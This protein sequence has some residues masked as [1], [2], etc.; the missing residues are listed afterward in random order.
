TQDS[1]AT[2]F[3]VQDYQSFSIEALDNTAQFDQATTHQRYF[4][5]TG[6]F[7]F[8]LASF[9]FHFRFCFRSTAT[10]ASCRSFFFYCCTTTA[11]SFRRY[12][13]RCCTTTTAS[14]RSFFFCRRTTTTATGSGFFYSSSAATTATG[15]GF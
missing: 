13:L 6:F 11:T 4:C 3:L 7:G 9:L 5:Q 12:F 14:C 8:R 1:A 15:S 10:T 2:L